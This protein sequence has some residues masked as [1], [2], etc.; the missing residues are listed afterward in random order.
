MVIK[1]WQRKPVTHEWRYLPIRWT[2]L[3]EGPCCE[4][5]EGWDHGLPTLVYNDGFGQM[6]LAVSRPIEADYVF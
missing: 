3:W 1:A 5:P 4:V 6:V 2:R